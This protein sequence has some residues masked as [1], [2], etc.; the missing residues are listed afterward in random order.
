MRMHLKAIDN[1]SN[2]YSETTVFPPKA[3]SPENLVEKAKLAIS[4]GIENIFLMGGTGVMSDEY[5]LEIIKNK[6]QLEELSR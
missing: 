2:C 6:N 5:W 4:Q 3:L 1:P